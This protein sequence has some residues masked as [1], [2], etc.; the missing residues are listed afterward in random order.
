MKRINLLIIGGGI[1]LGALA[2]I[3]WNSVGG[4]NHRKLTIDAVTGGEISATEYPDI[5]K[6][7]GGGN[8]YDDTIT[9]GSGTEASHNFTYKNS[10]GN[11][12]TVAHWDI[13]PGYWTEKAEEKYKTRNYMDDGEDSCYYLLGYELHIKQDTSV[14]AH[15][16]KLY[17]SGFDQ[18]EFEYQ[19]DPFQEGTFNYN[20]SMPAGYPGYEGKFKYQATTLTDSD[21]LFIPQ[22]YRSYFIK[23]A[24]TG[25]YYYYTPYFLSDSNDDDDNTETTS[26]ANDSSA[27][28]GPT[29]EY[30]DARKIWGT[31]GLGCWEIDAT[32]SNIIPGKNDGG[33][34]ESNSYYE[35]HD[36]AGDW[37]DNSGNQ[38]YKDYMMTSRLKKARDESITVMK[39]FSNSLPPIVYSLDVSYDTTTETVIFSF[40]IEENRTPDVKVTAEIL[41]K[42]EET[43]TTALQTH[44][45]VDVD[46]NTWTEKTVTLVKTDDAVKTVL[47]YRS[48]SFNSANE[49]TPYCK[50]S[51]AYKEDPLPKHEKTKITQLSVKAT[52][53][54][55]NTSEVALLTFDLDKLC[56]VA[57]KSGADKSAN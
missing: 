14:P 21:Y 5:H 52:D 55:G 27:D 37:F 38:E 32:Q 48:K 12:V 18:D 9:D 17:H 29:S 40:V 45:I 41:I 50:I 47:P 35:G 34:W 22:A 7:Y 56:G 1:G 36:D 25:I 33:G 26:D 23:D 19:A 11:E 46:S 28:D 4:E 13:T 39:A 15:E 16:F 31:Y 30:P 8:W 57:N 42:N 20:L 2:A 53:T 51:W 3:G 49:E 43:D 44:A 24:S 10:E 54:N 6:F